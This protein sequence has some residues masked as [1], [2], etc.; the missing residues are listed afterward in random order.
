MS[1]TTVGYS[2]ASMPAPVG[3]VDEFVEIGVLAAE[4]HGEVTSIHPT[5]P[6]YR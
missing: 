6:S 5:S 2:A 4:R 1:L 3:A